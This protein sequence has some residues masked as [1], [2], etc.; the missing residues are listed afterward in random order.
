MKEAMFFAGANGSGKS[1]LAKQTVF[2]GKFINAD[3]YA[4]DFLGHL[5]SGEEK[6][7]LATIGATKEIMNAIKSEKSFAYETVLGTSSTFPSEFFNRLKRNGYKIIVHYVGLETPEI[8][9]SRV[10]KR[11]AQGGHDIPTDK[12]RARYE[13]AMQ[14]LP[15]LM[16]ISDLAILYDNSI[17]DGDGARPFMIKAGTYGIKLG[18]IPN[19][20]KFL[21]TAPQKHN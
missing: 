16:D 7:R 13:K 17:D 21:F 3:L 1:T 4:E 8:N 15:Q 9:I 6:D 18:P 2:N 20:A 12:I 14:Y 10:K 5:P 19:W 11:V